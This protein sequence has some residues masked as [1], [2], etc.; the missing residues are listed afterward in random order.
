MT[1]SAS[2]LAVVIVSSNNGGWLSACVSALRSHAGETDFDVVVVDSGSTDETGELA[3]ALGAR[4]VRCPNRGFADA[5]NRGLEAVG[6][7]GALSETRH[8][9]R[10]GHAVHLVEAAQAHAKLGI[11]GVRQVGSAGFPEWS[12]RRSPSALRWLGEAVGSESLPW[13]TRSWSGERVLD[14]AAYA[15]E[16]QIDWTS[17]SCMLARSAMLRQIGGMDEQFFLYSEETDPRR[18]ARNAGWEVWHLPVLT[19]VHYGGNEQSDPGLAAQL[20]HS[21]RLY[22][23]K[24]GTR[25]DRVLGFLVL[26][27]GQAVRSA[28]GR[29]PQRRRG[30]RAALETLLGLR[31]P[32]FEALTASHASPPLDVAGRDASREVDPSSFRG[33]QRR[34]RASRRRRRHMPTDCCAGR[35]A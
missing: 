24:H 15:Q 13:R 7:V 35:T 28:L 4:V 11:A 3:E 19:I 17:G 30:A 16:R 23:R 9:G 5:K 1:S 2:T 26:V 8:G 32:P 21:R 12:I 10:R 14:A 25:I 22:L 29:S 27:L 31:P 6:G 33:I 34:P 20:V 18:R